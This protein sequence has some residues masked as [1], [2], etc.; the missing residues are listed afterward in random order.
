M[1]RLNGIPASVE[2]IRDA[3]LVL[4]FLGVSFALESQDTGQILVPIQSQYRAQRS[5]VC[6]EAE[7]DDTHRFGLLNDGRMHFGS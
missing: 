3:D 7:T 2:V 6:E 1:F 5:E 4:T